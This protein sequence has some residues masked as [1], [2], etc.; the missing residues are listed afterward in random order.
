MARR[1]ASPG[2]AQLTKGKGV[3]WE[4]VSP[5]QPAACQGEPSK[6]S[7]DLFSFF[8]IQKER[9]VAFPGKFQWTTI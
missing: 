4:M 9:L 2:A 7:K 5:S 3:C 1:C 8:V 6:R